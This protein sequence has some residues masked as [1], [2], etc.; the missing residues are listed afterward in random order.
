MMKHWYVVHSKPRQEAEALR[1]LERQNYT[2]YLP[3]CHRNKRQRHAL[4]RVNEPMF[5][6][7]LFIQ[8]NPFD[9]N[10]A[11]IR[12]TRGVQTLLRFAGVPA[13]VPDALIACLRVREQ[14]ETDGAQAISASHADHFKAG[15]AVRLL[16]G[17]L[18]GYNALF[19]AASGQDRAYVLLS[20]LG[21]STRV[22]V[23]AAHLDAV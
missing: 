10:W 22:Q 18:Q 15:Q 4:V 1:Q 23:R 11:P 5:A 13:R 9:D 19:E 2:V 14:Q 17:P 7:Y 3:M 16:D 20:L 12:S 6:R 21:E 8:L